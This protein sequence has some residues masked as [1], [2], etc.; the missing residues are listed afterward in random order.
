MNKLCLNDY[1]KKYKEVGELKEKLNKMSLIQYN[2]ICKIINNIDNI[3]IIEI[4]S[5]FAL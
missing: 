4:A 2:F 5:S 3:D 1:Q